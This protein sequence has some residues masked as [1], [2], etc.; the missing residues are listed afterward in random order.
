MC[1]QKSLIQKESSQNVKIKEVL[2]A[3][4]AMIFLPNLYKEK[5]PEMTKLYINLVVPPL[6]RYI[7]QIGKYT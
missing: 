1:T 7:F 4:Y 6:L 5:F 3:F 2:N